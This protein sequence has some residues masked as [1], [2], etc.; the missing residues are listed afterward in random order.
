M[1]APS[2]Q[3]VA[4]PAPGAAKKDDAVLRAGLQRSVDFVNSELASAGFPVTLDFSGFT[5]N[6]EHASQ[7]VNCICT[8]LQQRQKDV[9][10]RDDLQYRLRRTSAD[11][12]DLSGQVARQKARLEQCDRDFSTLQNKFDTAQKALKKE[13]EK[14]VATREELKTTKSN[15]QYSKTQYNHD[16]RKKERDF[17]RLKERLQ[18][19][20]TEKEKTAK[21]AITLINPL[22]KAAASSSTGASARDKKQGKNDNDVMYAVVMQNYEDREKELLAE[23]HML[24]ETLFN[25]YS[26]LKNRFQDPDVAAAAAAEKEDIGGRRSRTQSQ[27]SDESAIDKAH[28]QMPFNLVKNSVQQRIRHVVLDLK[29]DW[30]NLA[31]SVAEQ[32]NNDVLHTLEER[33][34]DLDRQNN[35]C[36]QIIEEQNRLLEM[37]MNDPAHRGEEAS[38]GAAWDTSMMDL[39]E[40]KQELEDKCQT[41]ELERQRFTEAAIKLGVERAAL[42]REKSAF[43]EQRRMALGT[44]DF[45]EALPKTPRWLKDKIAVGTN[46]FCD[47]MTSTPA[48]PIQQQQKAYRDDFSTT[49]PR[50]TPGATPFGRTYSSVKPTR[51]IMEELRNGG[52][53]EADME[54]SASDDADIMIES[55]TLTQTPSSARN[56]IPDGSPWRRTPRTGPRTTTPGSN[57]YSPPSPARSSTIQSR[58]LAAMDD[59]HCEPTT[60]T[61]TMTASKSRSIATTVSTPSYIRSALK[62][63]ERS[64]TA[65]RSVRITVAD[66]D[67]EE[68]NGGRSFRPGEDDSK[69]NFEP[70]STGR[71]ANNHPSTSADLLRKGFIATSTPNNPRTPTDLASTPS[72]QPYPRGHDGLGSSRSHGSA[73]PV[74]STGRLARKLIP[75]TPR[76]RQVIAPSV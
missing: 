71:A 39:Q 33:I 30:D 22:P 16:L 75:G 45:L 20:V 11:N 17:H 40:Q 15:L 5:G 6:M 68:N 55:D 28:F 64:A 13:T 35:E 66:P 63:A 60:S 44:E 48:T 46:K 21:T 50:A 4:S 23:N 67:E 32:N 58:P 59:S 38:T 18:R 54:H 10:Y 47:P 65:A 76:P 3:P 8:L 43:Q 57:E 24:R 36:R 72:A 27:E 14:L 2:F 26:E 52:R 56:S 51:S 61:M 7:V 37:S 70:R 1:T 62:K 12:D 69:E 49:A 34:A 31:Q 74:T 9:A 53:N 73:T 41:L 25:T 42:L 19:T 29:D